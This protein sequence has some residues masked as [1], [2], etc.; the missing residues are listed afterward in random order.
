MQ[1]SKDVVAR[2]SPSRAALAALGAGLVVLCTGC[3][4]STA[5]HHASTLG[6][7]IL[8]GYGPRSPQT[9]AHARSVVAGVRAE[10]LRDINS[11]GRKAKDRRS[12]LIFPSPGRRI[13]LARLRSASAHYHFTV[14]EV[15]FYR[16]FQLAPF[17]VVRSSYPTRF[18]HDTRFIVDALGVTDPK[19]RSPYPQLY[20]QYEGFYLEARDGEGVPFLTVTNFIRGKNWGG[21]QW[22]RSNDLYPFGHG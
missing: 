22:A 21:G 15:R 18:S 5:A 14:K 19:T 1:R 20:W 13:F 16:P 9:P 8:G 3:G 17:V 12:P 7:P 10:W 2:M 4:H 6:A 11:R